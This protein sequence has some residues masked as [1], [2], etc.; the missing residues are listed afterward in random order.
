MVAARGKLPDRVALPVSNALILTPNPAGIPC[1]PTAKRLVNQWLGKAM[2]SSPR[3]QEQIRDMMEDLSISEEEARQRWVAFKEKYLAGQ[4]R[5]YTFLRAHNPRVAEMEQDPVYQRRIAEHVRE[6]EVSE[7]L[8][9]MLVIGK[10]LLNEGALKILQKQKAKSTHK[11]FQQMLGVTVTIP[12]DV[13]DALG[14]ENA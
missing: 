13:L 9:A 1:F 11:D 12:K 3:D 8:A 6:L 5:I 14:I 2:R 4:E 10:E 7:L